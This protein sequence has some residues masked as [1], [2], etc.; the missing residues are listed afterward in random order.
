MPVAVSSTNAKIAVHMMFC[1]LVGGYTEEQREQIIQDY[2]ERSNMLGVQ[3]VFGM[4]RPTL[5]KWLKK[6]KV[7]HR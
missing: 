7:I 4:S 5:L 6:T 3:R 1:N 2:Y